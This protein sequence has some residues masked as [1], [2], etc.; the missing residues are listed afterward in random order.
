MNRVVCVNSYNKSSIFVLSDMWTGRP[1][2]NLTRL[3][4]SKRHGI[5]RYVTEPQ[6]EKETIRITFVLQDGTRK[7]IEAPIGKHILELAREHDLD[8]E[9]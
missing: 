8:L 1:A 5:R 9:G 3:L 7:Q 4:F 6:T 2:R